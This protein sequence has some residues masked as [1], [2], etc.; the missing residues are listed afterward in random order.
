MAQLLSHAHIECIINGH[1]FTGWAEDDPPYEW[2]EEDSAEF[3]TG[4]DGGMYGLSKPEFGGMFRFKLQPASPTT[5]WAMQQEQMRKNSVKS[6]AAVRIYSGT[7]NDPVAST[8]WRMA[9]GVI[10]NFPSTRTANLTYEGTIM[11]EELTSQVDGG[12]FHPPL[13]S[14]AS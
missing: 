10:Q 11:F 8:S 1:R 12:K 7:F 2:E 4:Q 3:K 6:R 9:G 14:D 13:T 5:Q